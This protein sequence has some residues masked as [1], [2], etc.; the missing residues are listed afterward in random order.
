MAINSDV[1]R[2]EALFKMLNDND[3]S[4][5][6]KLFIILDLLHEEDIS[7]HKAHEL[8]TENGIF[9]K[10]WIELEN[11]CIPIFQKYYN[12][13]ENDLKQKTL[14][15]PKSLPLDTLMGFSGQKENNKRETFTVSEETQSKMPTEEKNIF[16]MNIFELDWHN[17]KKIFRR[18]SI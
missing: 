5:E 14:K 15:K 6:M 4:K 8:C 1:Y 17:F 18:K 2:T 3:M 16:Q 11:E 7:L 13:G 10:Y 9:S 12:S